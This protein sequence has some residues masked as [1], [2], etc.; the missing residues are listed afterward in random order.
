MESLALAELEARGRPADLRGRLERARTRLHADPA[1]KLSNAELAREAA[2]S[3]FHFAREFRRLYGRTPLQYRTELRLDLAKRLLWRDAKSVTEV[4]F[5]VGFQ[6]LGS[7]TS[8][9]T[10]EVGQSPARYRRRFV[11]ALGV[12]TP[13]APIPACFLAFYGKSAGSEKFAASWGR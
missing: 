10:R 3:P 5:E 8:L 11:Q 4:C 12:P 7:F 9:F 1:A 2:L 6:S 13:V